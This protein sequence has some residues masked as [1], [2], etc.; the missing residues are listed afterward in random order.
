MEEDIGQMA[1]AIWYALKTHGELSLAQLKKLVE[2]KGPIFEWAI[3]WLAREGQ[4]CAN[5]HEALPQ[6]PPEIIYSRAASFRGTSSPTRYVF[7]GRLFLDVETS[8]EVRA[9][10]NGDAL[11]CDVPRD[12]GRLL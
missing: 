7:R 4:G 10:I 5:P 1:G 8:L 11:G 9:F 2:A 6:H 3:G 12:N